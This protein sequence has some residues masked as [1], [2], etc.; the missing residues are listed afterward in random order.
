MVTPFPVLILHLLA[1]RCFI[2]KRRKLLLGWGRE[3]P[4]S[5]ISSH[6]CRESSQSLPGQTRDVLTGHADIKQ[7]LAQ[8][9]F[10][11]CVVVGEFENVLDAVFIAE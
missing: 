1:R 4:E 7:R 2:H 5:R 10:H 9:L 8:I 3:K 6:G 11:K